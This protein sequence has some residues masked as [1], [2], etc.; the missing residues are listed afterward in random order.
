LK[1]YI[2][3]YQKKKE[4]RKKKNRVYKE[5]LS[6]FWAR[7]LERREINTDPACYWTY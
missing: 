1:V 5:M 3:I 4:K 7:G 6:H 2:V